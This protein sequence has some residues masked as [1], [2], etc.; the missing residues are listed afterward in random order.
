MYTFSV[1]IISVQFVFKLFG[2]PI[3]QF[4]AYTMKVIVRTKFDIYVFIIQVNGVSLFEL[5]EFDWK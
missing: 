3:F 2:I 4:W 1:Y 5:T